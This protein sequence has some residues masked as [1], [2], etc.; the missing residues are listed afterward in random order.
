MTDS[1]AAFVA[2]LVVA[3]PA[4]CGV[5]LL[6]SPRSRSLAGPLGATASLLA[7]ACVGVLAFSAMPGVL[8]IWAWAPELFVSLAW[9]VDA[10][11][12]SLAGLVS[13]VGGLVLFFGGAYFGPS[14]KGR[15]A[16]GTLL[17]FEAS[18]L[19][20]ILSDELLALFIF[21]ELTGLCSFFLINTDAD[22]RADT[23]SSAQQALV[24]TVAGALPMLVGFLYLATT[25][26][27][28]SLTDLR[29]AELPVAV[30]TAVLLLVLPGIVTKSAQVPFHFW[31]PGAMAAPTPISAYLHSATMVKAGLISTLR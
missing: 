3:L 17:V 9:R 30:Q 20:L 29:A 1:V 8:S 22:K 6:L 13:F 18:M 15:V 24:V 28:S 10:A 31:L 4:S 5:W 23:F 14:D 21:W 25:A 16:I 12:L 2:S 7:T 27:S 11:T 26:G 19:G